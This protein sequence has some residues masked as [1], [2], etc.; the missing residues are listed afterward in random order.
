LQVKVI[1]QAPL[2]QQMNVS[3]MVCTYTHTYIH[4]CMHTYT[5]VHTNIHQISALGVS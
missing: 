1:T 2:L 4:T 5:Y 3:C